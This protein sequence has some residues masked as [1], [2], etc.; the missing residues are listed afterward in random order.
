MTAPDVGDRA[1]AFTLPATTGGTV[2]LVD[3]LSG[4]HAVLYF[5]R[6]FS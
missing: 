4:T 2:S 5:F 6:E 1:P 3:A